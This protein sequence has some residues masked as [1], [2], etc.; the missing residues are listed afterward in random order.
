M[1]ANPNSGDAKLETDYCYCAAAVVSRD[2]A[3]TVGDERIANI[4]TEGIEKN[5]GRH[6][7]SAAPGDQ[8]SRPKG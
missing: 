7:G 4:V 8:G 3:E 2:A 1:E 5:L 6:A